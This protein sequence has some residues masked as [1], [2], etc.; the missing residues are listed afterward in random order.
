MPFF[1]S[2]LPNLKRLCKQDKNVTHNV[3]QALVDLLSIKSDAKSST[4]YSLIDNTGRS[5]DTES[6]IFE[7]SMTA[8]GLLSSS[9]VN[10]KEVR[11][12]LSG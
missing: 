6:L 1:K 11:I 4:I 5:N 7:L 2:P 12:G 9:L 8:I 10:E 3:A